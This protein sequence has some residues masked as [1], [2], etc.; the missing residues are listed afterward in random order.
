[1]AI[2]FDEDGRD[3]QSHMKTVHEEFTEHNKTMNY[4]QDQTIKSMKSSQ[5][6]INT[7]S[8]DIVN[9]LSP[10]TKVEGNDLPK[11]VSQKQE[12]DN[13]TQTL[14]SAFSSPQSTL[15]VKKIIEAPDKARELVKHVAEIEV[16]QQT[17]PQSRNPGLSA[18]KQ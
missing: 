9:L 7:I 16:I 2:L 13:T 5:K 18:P 8:H 12:K 4:C 14:E 3:S 1:M 17:P 10:N 15:K 6:N 11:N